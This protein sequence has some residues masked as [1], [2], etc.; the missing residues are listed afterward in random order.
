[1][2]LETK[3]QIEFATNSSFE[4]IDATISS[5]D[6]HKLWDMLQ[7]PY[8]DNIG[9]LVREY[10]SNSFDSHAEAMFIKEHSLKEIRAEYGIY[11]TV[12]DEELLLLKEHVEHCNN[13]A[14]AVSL[15]KDQTGWYWSTEDVGVG[16]SPTRVRTVFVNYLK[17]TKELSNTMIGAFGM[18]SK[19][20][21]SYSDVVFIRARY[22]GIESNYLLRKGENG[23]A[24]DVISE[25]PTTEKNGTEIKI[26]L[27]TENDIRLFRIACEKQL[28]YFNNVYFSYNTYVNNEY[29]I[30]K[31]DNWVA[32][33]KDKP[34]GG[35]HICLGTVAYPIDWNILEMSSIDL[36]IALQFEIGELDVIQ[37]REDVKYTPRTKE[38]ILAK[39]IELRKEFKDRWNQVDKECKSIEE[40][41]DNREI[42][43]T[44]SFLNNA[45]SFRIKDFIG[46]EHSGYFY[47]PFKDAGLVDKLLPSYRNGLFFEYLITGQFQARFQAQNWTP[48][49][50][51]FRSNRV[52]RITGTHEPKKSKF[53]LEENN[54]TQIL[55][56]RKQKKSLKDYK[57][58]LKLNLVHKSQWRTI[59]STYQKEI[60]KLVISLTKSY[61]KTVITQEWLDSQKQIRAKKDNT[62]IKV[63]KY[64]LK[65]SVYS[66]PFNA[67][68]SAKITDFQQQSRTTFI[69]GTQEDKQK[70]RLIHNT[71][72]WFTQIPGKFLTRLE[73]A[74]TN[75]KKLKDVKNL[76]TIDSFMAE[77]NTVFKRTMSF[78]KLHKTHKKEINIALGGKYNRIAVLKHVCPSL[79]AKYQNYER[80][81]SNFQ[82]LIDLDKETKF[83]SETCYQ[84]AKQNNLWDIKFEQ[85]FLKVVK[86]LE[87]V[88]LQFIDLNN[89][90]EHRTSKEAEQQNSE[91]INFVFD[92]LYMK[93]QIDPKYKTIPLNLHMLITARGKYQTPKKVKTPK[94]T[95][96]TLLKEEVE[97]TI[98]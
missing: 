33:T 16:L 60:Q 90:N 2:K 79:I 34:Y 68:Y 14:V 67:P 61:D 43:P 87:L 8:K 58:F 19:S 37:T 36:P 26:Y 28:A 98:N 39:I 70:M 15:E 4:S 25:E 80:I 5:T 94:V 56:L 55:L 77:D 83:L 85:D 84:L 32:T 40:Y 76:V 45:I 51:T 95:V 57:H 12:E 59:I 22:N 74:P 91:V 71:Y 1:M 46:I 92:Y 82:S 69:V 96:K 72:A 47:K 27:N 86:D 35:L 73:V 17:S 6:M 78:F 30:V 50:N 65:A 13:D 53:I 23:P 54:Y 89:F 3:K 31:G 11:N 48:D 63:V 21:L 18:G 10:V 81:F 66:N 62:V 97:L 44:L 29:Q 88:T 52:Y 42:V 24:L 75:I 7:N 20:G 93:K 49:F 64:D 38:A 9:S 41:Y